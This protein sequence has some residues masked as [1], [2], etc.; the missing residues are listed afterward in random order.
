MLVG[1]V[2]EPQAGVDITKIPT[3][4]QTQALRRH[5]DSITSARFKDEEETPD[6]ATTGDEDD[7]ADTMKNR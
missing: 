5:G 3:E 2:H 6:N 1:N 7:H 4:R